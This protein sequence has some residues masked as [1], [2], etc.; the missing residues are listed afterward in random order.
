V[1]LS[2]VDHHVSTIALSTKDL[3][4]V[5]RD[6]LRARPAGVVGLV[7]SKAL[8]WEFLNVDRSTNPF[9]TFDDDVPDFE[10]G[11]TYGVRGL[12]ETASPLARALDASTGGVAHL[13]IW[14][15]GDHREALIRHAGDLSRA[16]QRIVGN[17]VELVRQADPQVRVSKS[18]GKLDA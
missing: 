17:V 10:V 2:Y 13:A 6:G 1:R 15:R 11:A 7:A 3:A 12:A 16:S 14:D 5:F 9:A 8:E 4:M 18:H